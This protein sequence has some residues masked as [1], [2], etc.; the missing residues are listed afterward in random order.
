MITVQNK[1]NN[2][3]SINIIDFINE[4]L[5][6]KT[7]YF[8]RSTDD[9]KFGRITVRKFVKENID[10]L[11]ELTIHQLK[12][13]SSDLGIGTTVFLD[14]FRRILLEKGPDYYES[15]RNCEVIISDEKPKTNNIIRDL[16]LYSDAKAS[17][18]RFGVTDAKGNGVFYGKIFDLEF[19]GEQSNSEMIA[20]KKAVLFASKVAA[21]AKC[22]IRLTLF[23]DAQ[24]LL[25]A[26]KVKLGESGGGKAREL[27][28]FALRHDIDLEVKF[29][30]GVDN[31]ADKYTVGGGYRKIDDNDLVALVS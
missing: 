10:D 7:K 30:K 8:E 29:V 24:W 18:E 21:A 3:N 9:L 5:E 26:N 19:N 6:E 14:T 13:V 1:N 15:K 4:F 20:A 11:R 22:K 2:K 23:V 28:D 12:A 17:K 16:T 25:Y 31:P 27:G